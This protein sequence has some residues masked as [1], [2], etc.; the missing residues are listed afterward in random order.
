L[1][2]LTNISEK[3]KSTS[4]GAIQGEKL[5]KDNRYWREII[6]NEL[7]WKRWKKCW[8]IP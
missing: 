4:P 1:A 8:H 7:T 3:H 5:V 2:V 6:C